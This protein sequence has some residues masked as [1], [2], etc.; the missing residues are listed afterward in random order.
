MAAGHMIVIAA[1]KPFITSAEVFVG[2]GMHKP[3]KGR[4]GVIFPASAVDYAAIE[5]KT[6]E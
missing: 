5:D 1:H 2:E 3:C 4:H 6:G